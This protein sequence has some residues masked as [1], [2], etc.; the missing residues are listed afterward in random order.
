MVNQR[1]AIETRIEELVKREGIVL[2]GY[3]RLEN[4]QLPPIARGLSYGI[5][6]GY[7]LS[8]VIINAIVDRPTKEYL[9]HYR[10]IN[11]LLNQVSLIVTSVIQEEGYNAL[12]IPASQIVDWKEIRGDVS[13]KLI[14]AKAGLCWLGRSSLAVTPDYGARV[15]Y[16]SILTDLPLPT[17]QSLDFNCGDCRRCVEICPCGAIGMSSDKFDRNAC[18]EQLRNFAKSENLGT[19]YICGFCVKVC[20]GKKT[21][22]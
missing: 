4:V 22:L 14:A 8:D 3:A 10:Q 6:L 11:S 1:K 17:A 18:L 19:H 13:H 7:R 9:H 12:P 2:C 20:Q 5:S 16:V 21:K 15:R